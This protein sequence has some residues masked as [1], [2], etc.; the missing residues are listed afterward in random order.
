MLKYSRGVGI[1]PKSTTSHP[2]D[3]RPRLRLLAKAGELI[4]SYSFAQYF[5]VFFSKVLTNNTSYVIL[6]EYFRV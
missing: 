6:S 5:N 3:I 2:V 1:V 4:C